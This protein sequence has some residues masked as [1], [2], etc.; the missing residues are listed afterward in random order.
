MDR[1]FGNRGSMPP[2]LQGLTRSAMGQLSQ[3]LGFSEEMTHLECV[4]ARR[5]TRIEAHLGASWTPKNQ[6]LRLLV[7]LSSNSTL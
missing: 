4:R 5:E 6:N 7:R 2:C 1:F 3:K